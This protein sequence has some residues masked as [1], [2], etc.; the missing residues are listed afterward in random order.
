M[1]E[2]CS[3]GVMCRSRT[4]HLGLCRSWACNVAPPT[5][6]LVM[7][8]SHHQN[9]VEEQAFGVN[10]KNVFRG[11]IITIH[12]PLRDRRAARA[13]PINPLELQRSTHCHRTS[14][15]QHTHL[16]CLS[17]PSHVLNSTVNPFTTQR[18]PWPPAHD[19][20]HRHRHKHQC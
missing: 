15:I 3:V 12:S 4:V 14:P 8:S 6:L 18:S 19:K 17:P 2:W 7:P 13:R 20:I 9:N 5:G 1:G 10:V 11:M 16:L